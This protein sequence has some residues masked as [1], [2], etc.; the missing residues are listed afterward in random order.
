MP[1]QEIWIHPVF[2]R[3]GKRRMFNGGK[4]AREVF[5]PDIFCQARRKNGLVALVESHQ[6]VVKSG[7]IESGKANA[8]FG[9]QSL[10]FVFRPRNHVTGDK[11]LGQVDASQGATAFVVGQHDLAEDIL[12]DPRFDHARPRFASHTLWDAP[13]SR[14]VFGFDGSVFLGRE[15]FF[16]LEQEALAVAV[17]FLPELRAFFAAMGHAGNAA[18]LENRIAGG[19][20]D[21]TKGDRIRSPANDLRQM[22]DCWIAR[23]HLAERQFE[24]EIEDENHLVAG[25][26]FVFSHGVLSPF[27][28]L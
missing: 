11:Q 8:V 21:E 15:D 7:I 2:A 10:L 20:I 19:V 28:A 9:V 3:H 6:A 12:V 27:V 5:L 17:E 14:F 23:V 13:Q 26:Q 18:L 1:S 22:D 4:V 25:P 16:T 24:V